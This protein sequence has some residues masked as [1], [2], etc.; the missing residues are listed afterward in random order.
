MEDLKYR[1]RSPSP[2]RSSK[3]GVSFATIDEDDPWGGHNGGGFEGVAEVASVSEGLSERGDVPLPPQP[4]ASHLP[5]LFEP[6]GCAVVG[7]RGYGLMDSA[8]H[9]IGCQ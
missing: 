1:R 5:G 9:V 7:H 6:T 2:A 8:R 3:T 4:F